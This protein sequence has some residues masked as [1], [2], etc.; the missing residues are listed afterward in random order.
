MANFILLKLERNYEFDSVKRRKYEAAHGDTLTEDDP[1]S[2]HDELHS[3]TMQS[4][5]IDMS[6][7][8]HSSRSTQKHCFTA[9]VARV[10][11]T[12]FSFPFGFWMLAVIG[13]SY[14]GAFIVWIAFARQMFEV[15]FRAACTRV[16][17]CNI[18]LILHAR[19]QDSTFYASS[20][21]ESSFLVAA[22]AFITIPFNPYI[23]IVANRT[24]KRAAASM[25]ACVLPCC[26]YMLMP[27]FSCYCITFQL[28]NSV[29]GTCR[30]EL[31]ALAHCG[32]LV[33]A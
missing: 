29:F 33:Q 21:N 12:L 13:L 14:Y 25:Y 27:F 26:S 24:P 22:C 16:D 4:L 3:H 5:H 15:R 28:P 11:R 23:G 30:R 8:P 10:F 32:V 20:P 19:P 18:D 9:A 6:A 2:S 17:C 7:S 31:L 1:L